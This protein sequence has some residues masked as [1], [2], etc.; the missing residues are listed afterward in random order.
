MVVQMAKAHGARVIASAGTE[1]KVQQCLKLGADFAVNYREAD[2]PDLVQRFAPDGV[3]LF[4]DTTRQPDFELAV[5]LMA[6]NARMIL[7]AAAKPA[8][9]FP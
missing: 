9:R 6:E 4:W 5:S 1:T 3:N 2:W 7:M 8:R